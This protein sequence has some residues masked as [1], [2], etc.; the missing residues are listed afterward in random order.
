MTATLSHTCQRPAI[1]EEPASSG[2]PIQQIICELSNDLR[3]LSEQT[4]PQQDFERF[5]REVHQR[6]VAAERAVL[7]GEL[8]RLDVD[9]PEVTIGGRRHRRVLRS[10]ETYLS[11]VGPITVLR[12][13]YRASTEQAV[14]AMDCGR[15]SSPDTG[16]RWRRGTRAGQHESVQEQSGPAAE[17]PEQPLGRAPRSVRGVA[18]GRDAYRARCGDGAGG[19]AGRGDGADE[20][21]GSARQACGCAG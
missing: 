21:R 19:V 8:Q 16:R 4:S 5:E 9:L 2:D 1:A 11:A 12:T 3:E 13:L 18:A 17:A 14:V 20:G 15:G 7:A 10:T 6:F